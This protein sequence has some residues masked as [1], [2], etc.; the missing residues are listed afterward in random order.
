MFVKMLWK[1][2][3]KRKYNKFLKV[4]IDMLFIVGI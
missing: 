4:E 3:R 1:E 2:G